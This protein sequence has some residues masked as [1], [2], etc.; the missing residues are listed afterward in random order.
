MSS[1]HPN[2]RRRQVRPPGSTSP[3]DALF[4]AAFSQVE[5]AAGILR[6]ILPP[7]ILARLDLSTLALQPGSFVSAEL[8]SRHTDL[9]FTAKLSGRTAFV[10]V[11]LE[12]QSDLDPLMAFRLL[13]YMVRIW[14]RYLADHPKARRLPAI[15]PLVVHHSDKGW[16]LDTTFEALLDLDPP[17][18][19]ALGEH[20]PR[21]RF[22]LDDI[23]HDTDDALKS[24]PMTAFGRAAFWCLRHGRE[25]AELLR[26]LAGL[27]D[28]IRELRAAPDRLAALATILRYIMVVSEPLPPEELHA[29]L[30][31]VVGED[32]EEEIVT[33]ADQLREEGRLKGLVEGERK[34]LIE[35]ERKGLVQG[36]REGLV[37]GLVKGK[38]DTLLKLLAIRFGALPEAVTARVRVA[39]VAQLDRWAEGVLT[40]PALDALFRDA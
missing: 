4:R 15:L 17:T 25:P 19:A 30:M 34:G 7:A 11:L 2:R 20:M 35:G 14:E 9:L 3:H 18:L 21:C 38:R 28:L 10:Y 33:V 26:R 1:P 8:T 12:H 36:K 23:S 13:V 5:H 40:A 37:E 24:R 39:G 32:A 16:C 31:D 22:V 27:R 29:M 6:T